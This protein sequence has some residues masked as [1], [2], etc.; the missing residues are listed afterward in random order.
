MRDRQLYWLSIP[1][2]WISEFNRW[3]RPVPA[4]QI[5]F[6]QLPV[7]RRFTSAT[8]RVTGDYQQTS[9]C[10]ASLA[11][12]S[13]CAFSVS[14]SPTATG[15]RPGRLDGHRQRFGRRSP[16]RQP[17]RTG[18]QPRACCQPTPCRIADSKA[19]PWIAGL[20][21]ACWCPISTDCRRTAAA[22]ARN[23][24]PAGLPEP[25]GDSWLAQTV[26]VPTDADGPD[27]ERSGLAFDVDDSIG[28]DWQEAQIRD[29]NGNSSRKCSKW[30]PTAQTWTHG[31]PSIYSASKARPFSCTSTFM[32]T[33]TLRLSHLH[34]S[35]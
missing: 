11:P 1:T 35:G 12:N 13:S 29:T 17:D 22:S 30:R 10:G 19:A 6:H 14:S 34:V 26:T 8:S 7:R 2:P 5:T 27:L 20:P 18:N 25:N 3:D 23:S 24:E 16:H 9:T 33:A 15:T 28:Y 4:Q 31:Q 21:A 32:K